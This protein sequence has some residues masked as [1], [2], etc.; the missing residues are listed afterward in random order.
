M[1]A[2]VHLALYWP[3]GR[4]R[5]ERLVYEYKTI[6]R[7]AGWWGG[8][9]SEDSIAGTINEEAR[10]GWRLVRWESMR[11][12]WW[13]FLP[14]PKMLF[15]FERPGPAARIPTTPRLVR[16]YAPSPPAQRGREAATIPAS[17]DALDEPTRGPFVR[18]ALGGP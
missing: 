3:L 7:W 6:T 9:G 12:F 13:W 8:W 18:R 16:D 5:E 4:G 10:A 14:R 1:W 15:I 2:V 17:T 11:L